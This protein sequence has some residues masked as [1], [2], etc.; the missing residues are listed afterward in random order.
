MTAGTG[1]SSASSTRRG[2]LTGLGQHTM[3]GYTNSDAVWNRLKVSHLC[4]HEFRCVPQR[5]CCWRED[6]IDRSQ[7]RHALDKS[8][9]VCFDAQKRY[10]QAISAIR[11]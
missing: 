10:P 2:D 3:A 11:T 5:S 7:V 1:L 4:P 9:S 6:R 8:S